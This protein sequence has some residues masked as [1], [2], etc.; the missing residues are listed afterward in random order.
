MARGNEG[1]NSN[2][3][4]GRLEKEKL[5]ERKSLSRLS[6][7]KDPKNEAAARQ[8]TVRAQNKEAPAL[9]RRRAR[10]REQGHPQPLRVCARARTR[11]PVRKR[12]RAGVGVS[13]RACVRLGPFA[14]LSVVGVQVGA[15]AQPSTDG[16]I[17][18][19]LALRRVDRKAQRR[20]ARRAVPRGV[21]WGGWQAGLRAAVLSQARS[22][23]LANA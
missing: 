22:C 4:K 23:A 18:A 7:G 15:G 11:R 17:A 14:E 12:L 10:G 9:I 16:S 1:V 8:I 21:P 20:R 6:Q 2:R 3:G 19:A 13:V 5:E